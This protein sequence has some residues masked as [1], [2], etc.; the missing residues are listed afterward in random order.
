[1]HDIITWLVTASKNGVLLLGSG[2]PPLKCGCHA[3][4]LRW[5]ELT[6]SIKLLVIVLMMIAARS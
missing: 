2:A 5:T 3:S 1:M 4:L 6:L